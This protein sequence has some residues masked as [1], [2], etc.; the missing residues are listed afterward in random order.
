MEKQNVNITLIITTTLAAVVLTSL[1]LAQLSS[2]QRIPNTGNVKATI[3]I[4]VY[5]DSQCTSPL[6]SINLGDVQAGQSY[7]RTIYLKNN[8]NVKV[9]LSMTVGNWT[10]SS[11]SSY[12]TLSWNRQDNTLNP[13]ESFAASLNLAVASTAVGGSFSFDIII[14][15]T[16]SQ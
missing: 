3:G 11:A 12:L 14:T 15:A 16:E 4:G 7:S 8:G 1:V 6:T 9:R 2:Y 5:S 13:G 10:P